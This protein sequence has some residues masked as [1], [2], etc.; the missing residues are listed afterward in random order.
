MSIRPSPVDPASPHVDSPGM[1]AHRRRWLW[2]L[3]AVPVVAALTAAGSWW[4]ARAASSRIRSIAVL[5]FLDLSHGKDQDWFGDGITDEIIDGLARIPGLHVAAHASAFAFKNQA[6]DLRR[7][8][9]QLGVAAVLEGSIQN[10]GGRQRIT[11]QLHRTDDGYQLWSITFDRLANDAFHLQR[12]MV[13]A[14]AQRIHAVVPSRPTPRQPSPQAYDAYLD[15]RAFFG[16]AGGASVTQAAERFAEATRL[17]SDFALAWAWQSI[18]NEYRV[19]YG[20]VRSNEAMPA[21]RDAA[22]R[23][24]ALDADSAETHLAL[25]IVKLQYDW[26]WN[27]AK[28]EFD[29]TIQLSPGSGFA[30]HWLAHWYETQ[31]RLGDALTE[32]QS[33]LTLDPLSPEMLRDVVH[34]YLASANPAGALPFA[35]KAA[36]LFPHDPNALFYAGQKE[37]ARQLTGELHT[38]LQAAL[39]SAI[40]G[41]PGDARTLLDQGDDL[42][43]EQQVPAAA[44]AGL[45]AAVEDWDRL[46]YWLNVAYDERSVHLPYARLDPRI[47]AAD[48]RFVELLSRMNLPPSPAQ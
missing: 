37:K 44:L 28:R 3:A 12:E 10:D 8:G 9:E 16:R 22:E 2:V 32:M 40:E 35:Q 45:A 27:T 21:A 14:L 41:E 17:D 31:G 39:W 48:P 24:V 11:A 36:N 33:A 38:P 29:R 23:A 26:D 25:A 4:Y 20:L 43:V 5:P 34:E 19:D 30:Q 47:P 1:H 15:G 42:H 13:R 6:R 7:I 46:F 18:A